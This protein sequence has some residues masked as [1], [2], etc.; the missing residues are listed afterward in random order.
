MRLN[1]SVYVFSMLRTLFYR[2]LGQKHQTLTKDLAH[3]QRQN[4]RTGYKAHFHCGILIRG[5]ELC[6]SLGGRP[7]LPAP[8][9]NSPDD[10]LC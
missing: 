5:L 10:G 1:T 6:E 7:G 9:C 2:Q 3:T 4:S 8:I